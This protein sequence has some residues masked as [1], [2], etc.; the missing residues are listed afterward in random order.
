MNFRADFSVSTKVA[1]EILTEKGSPIL[2]YTCR[3]KYKVSNPGTWGIFLFICV[4]LVSF[5]TILQVSAYKPCML[6]SVSSRG[7]ITFSA[8]VN[9]VILLIPPANCLLQSLRC[10]LISLY[11]ACHLRPCRLG[12]VSLI[13]CTCSCPDGS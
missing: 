8:F 13:F 5:R 6:H 2:K 3:T 12:L 11:W 7:F 10:S 9:S 4:F 1:I